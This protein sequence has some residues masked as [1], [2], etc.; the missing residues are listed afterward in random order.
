MKTQLDKSQL[1]DIYTG[2]YVKA[3]HKTDNNRLGRLV[4]SFDLKPSDII[5]DYACGNGLL[6]EVVH[7]RIHEYF[8]VDFSEE[9]I[10]EAKIRS[11]EK[12][13]KN[14]TFVKNDIITFCKE[15]ENKF[16]KAFAMDFTEHI[17]NDEFNEIFTSIK[18]SIKKD[19]KLFIHTPN[20]D[21][22]LEI[23]KKTGLLRQTSGHIAVRTSK[24]YKEILKKIG[25]T[26]IEVIHLPHYIRLLSRFNFLS[27]I[28]LIGK[29]FNARLLIIC[30]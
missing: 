11:K 16:N 15:N 30:S 19:G 20:G 26:N 8:G 5:A 23:L 6:L 18:R 1:R 28:P 4:D 17:Y 9:F 29:F 13:I 14:G 7:D 3:Y 10:S 25:F 22:F 12:N 2:E 24:Q 21:Y 27:K